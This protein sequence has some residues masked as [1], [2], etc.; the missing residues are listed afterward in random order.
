MVNNHQVEH[1]SIELETPCKI[2]DIFFSILIDLGATNFFI[3]HDA[4]LKLKIKLIN[5]K[6]FN[7]VEMSSGV[8]KK[9]G[10][11]VKD[12]EIDLDTYV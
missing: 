3:S 6:D 11:L 9:V 1:Q 5:Q 4:L 10:C 2:N 7:Q 8:K 12:C